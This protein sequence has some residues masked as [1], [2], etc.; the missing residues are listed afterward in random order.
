MTL[1]QPSA[2]SAMVHGFD[3]VPE[4]SKGILGILMI[5]HHCIDRFPN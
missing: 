5:K 3:E 1:P 4:L 2:F